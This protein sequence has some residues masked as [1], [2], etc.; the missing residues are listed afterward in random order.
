VGGE[1]GRDARPMHPDWPRAIRDQCAAA[2]VA[3][4]FK[5]FGEFA[6]DDDAPG[7]HTAMRRVGKARAGRTLEG[8]THDDLPQRP[9]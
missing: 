4:F 5:Q 8:R 3:F 7:A 6:P 2:G 1:S 9:A